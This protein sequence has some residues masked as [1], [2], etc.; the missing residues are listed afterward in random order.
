MRT[1]AIIAIVPDESNSSGIQ[2]SFNAGT[3]TYSCSCGCGEY[4]DERD[5]IKTF[6][7]YA[8]NAAM[9]IYQDDNCTD[10][11]RFVKPINATTIPEF[12]NKLDGVVGM[13]N[14]D[15]ADEDAN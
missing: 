10:A 11:W 7:S 14:I 4:A 9:I 13:D 15:S 12:L 2:F 1:Y 6:N 8:G 3:S 5:I